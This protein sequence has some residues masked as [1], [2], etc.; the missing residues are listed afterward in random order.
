MAFVFCLAHTRFSKIL[1]PTFTIMRFNLEIYFSGFMW[2]MEKSSNIGPVS[3]RSDNWLRLDGNTTILS[4]RYL[5]SSASK[6]SPSDPCFLAPTHVVPSHTLSSLEDITNR[7]VQKWYHALSMSVIKHTVTLALGSLAL[8][9]ICWH[10]VR[11][12]ARGG[13][14]QQPCE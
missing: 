11:R 3:H 7:T 12:G 6:M 9:E 1:K 5:S 14:V 13:K 4:Q 10:V 8:E 2:E